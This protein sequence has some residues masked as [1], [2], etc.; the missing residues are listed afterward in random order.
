[1]ANEVLYEADGH[2]AIITMNRPEKH[3]AIN[4]AVGE[5]VREGFMK[6]KVDRNIRA[7]VL[8]GAGERA[9]SAGADLIRM[10]QRESGDFGDSFWWPRSQGGWADDFYKPVIAAINGYCYAAAMNLMCSTTDIRVASDT[11]TF[12]YAEILRGFSGAGPAIALLPR[13]APYALAMEWLL[14]GKVFDAQEA[15]RAGLVNEVVPLS[16]VK[17]R[18][19]EVAQEV[20]KLAP[21]AV[22]AIKEAVVRGLS[23]DVPNAMRLANTIGVLTRYT[24]DAR[25]GPRAFAE[26]RPPVYKGR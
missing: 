24:E 4:D 2:V 6:A 10:A 12:C 5:G 14:T 16:R 21:I 26:K 19:V 8:T 1:M 3:N 25:E 22:R 7:V 13:Q 17:E 18:A 9:F 15:H 11:A 23:M 20:S